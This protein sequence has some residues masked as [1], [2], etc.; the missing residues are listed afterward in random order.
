MCI[1]KIRVNQPARSISLAR[2]LFAIRDD[3]LKKNEDN[4]NTT[5]DRY[6]CSFILKTVAVALFLSKMI[7]AVT[8]I[9]IAMRLMIQRFSVYQ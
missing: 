9:G 3:K 7:H 5:Y 4:K 1:F 8:I 2:T 6:R